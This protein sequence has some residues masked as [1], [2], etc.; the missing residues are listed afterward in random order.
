M[1]PNLKKSDQISLAIMRQCYGTPYDILIPN[2]YFKGMFEMDV[3]KLSKSGYVTEYEIKTSRSDFF[4]DFKKYRKHTLMQEGKSVCNRFFY[5]TPEN[6][7]KIEDV[8]KYAGWAV[9]DDRGYVH[10]QKNAPLL[11]KNLFSDYESLARIL[12]FREATHRQKVRFHEYSNRVRHEK[13]RN[14]LK[15]NQP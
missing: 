6:L 12:A 15:Q 13:E 9:V 5:V 1:E 3:F 10:V 2:F 7:I 11:N 8:P 4:A 14:L